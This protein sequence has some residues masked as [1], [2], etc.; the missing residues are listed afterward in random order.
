MQWVHT[1][2]STHKGSQK[3]LCDHVTLT[4][5]NVIKQ[6]ITRHVKENEDITQQFKTDI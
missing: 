2:E 6:T 4:I 5:G 1:Q 3:T